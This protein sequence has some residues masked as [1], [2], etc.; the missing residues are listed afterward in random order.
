MGAR[1][2]LL[3]GLLAVSGASLAQDAPPAGDPFTWLE[4][5]RGERALEWARAENRRTLGELQGDPRYQLYYDRALEILQARDRIP[6]VVLRPDGLYNF[7]Q[8]AD[9]VRGVLR[10]TTLA[11][12]RTETPQWETV[13]DLDALAR[14]EGKSWVYQGMLCLGPEERRCLLYLSEGGRDAN[15]VRELDLREGRFVEG[16][17][18]LPEGKQLVSWEDRDTLLVAREWGPGTM[19]AS[20]YPFVVKRVRRGQALEEAEEVYRGRPEDVRVAPFVL[21]DSDG[22]VHGIGA[23]RGIDFFHREY[24]LFRPS[25]PL[26]VPIPRRA[27]IAGMVDGHLLVSTDEAW[28]YGPGRYFAADSL[29]SYNLAAWE[30][31]PLRARPTLIW[32]PGPRQTLGGIATTQ[33]KLILGILDNVRGRAFVLD[34]ERRRWR[35]RELALPPSATISL[36]SASDHSDEA[37]LSVTNYLAPTSLWYFDGARVEALKTTPAR[38]DA[39]NHVVEQLE[40]T[41]RDGTRVPYFLIRPREIRMDGS[42]PTLLYGYGGFQASQLPAYSGTMGRLWLEQGNAYV[43]ANLRGGGEFGPEWHQSAQGRHKQRTWDDYIAVAEDLIRRNVTS[44]RRL[45]VVGGSQGGLLVGTAIT[46]RPE[47]FNAAIIQVPL[48]DMLRYHLI[49]A[50]ASWIGEYGDPRIPE[51]RAWL[52]AYSPYQLL[53]PGRTYPTPFIETSTADDRVHPAHGRKAAARLAALGQPYYYYENMEGGHAAAANLQE[54]ARRVALEYIY[55]ARR[56]VD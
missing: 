16:G 49:G 39:S 54:T 44:P 17:F 19:T 34:Y 53:T 28:N 32:A 52:E 25:G 26:T 3:A 35:A 40:A 22:V 2:W 7:W 45:G 23:L 20:G 31:D 56:L 12:F 46:Q 36:T 37:L 10:R 41:S 6:G 18:S 4:E 8:D 1:A 47:L 13:L 33:G 21:R 9:H 30:R 24:I 42:T 11:S 5:I 27:S 29:V 51:Q 50:G 38:F 14:A 55:A 48:F 43:V 15:H